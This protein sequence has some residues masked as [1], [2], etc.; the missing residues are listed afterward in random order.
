[1]RVDGDAGEEYMESMVHVMHAAAVEVYLHSRCTTHLR[2]EIFLR[3]VIYKATAAIYTSRDIVGNTQTTTVV[4]VRD[5]RARGGK[6]HFKFFVMW[7]P[8]RFLRVVC[9]RYMWYSG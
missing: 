1:M 8:R 7:T 9:C 5:S 2:A 6:M 3:G 4:V